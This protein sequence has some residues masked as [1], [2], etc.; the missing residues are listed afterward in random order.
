MG[1]RKLARYTV[2]CRY[3]Y[4]FYAAHTMLSFFVF[5]GDSRPRAKGQGL[6]DYRL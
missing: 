6:A 4:Y 2:H 1:E 5:H 3:Y